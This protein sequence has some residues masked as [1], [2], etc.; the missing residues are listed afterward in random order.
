MRLLLTLCA[1]I[2]LSFLYAQDYSRCKIY[3]GN[4][5]LQALAALGIAVDHGSGK[6]N[7]FFISDF[8]AA[9]IQAIA[10]HG[11]TYEVLIPDVKAHYRDQNRSAGSGNPK[12]ASCAQNNTDIPLPVTPN[13]FHLGTMGGYYTYEEFLAELDAMATAYPQLITLKAPIST[14]ESHEGRPLYWVRISDNPNADEAEPEVLYSSIHHAREPASLSQLIYYMWYLLENY[15]DNGEIAFLLNNTELYFVPM[16]NPDGY[17]YNQVNDPD[18]GGMWRKNRRDNGNG[19]YGVD[20][21]RNYSYQWGTT[22][23]SMDPAT[24]TYPGT[25]AFSEPETQAMKWF[26]ENRDFQLAL[27]AHTY[28]DKLLHPIGTTVE[29]FAEDHAFFEAITGH[30]VKYNGYVHQKSSALYPA[31]GDSDDYMYKVDLTEK[32]EILAMTP[33]IGSDDDGFWPA[34]ADI[35][36][37]CQEMLFTNLTLAHLTHRYNIV[38]DT[39]P[40]RISAATGNFNH[41]AYRLGL[42]DGTISVSITP[43]AGIQSVG[44]PV[45]HSLASMETANG[46]IAYV[47]NADIDYDDEIKYVLNT[48]YPG[49]TKHDTI[50]K[51]FGLMTL[52]FVDVADN[53]ANWT[54]NWATTTSTYYSAT[55]SFTDSPGSNYANMT[56]RTY[57]LNDT[58]DLTNA[59]AAGVSFYA[60]WDIES[61]Y[62]YARMEVSTDNGATWIGQC[63]NYTVAGTSG[64]GSVQPE[65]QPVYEG[66]QPQWVNEEINLDDYLGE[67]IR[68]RFILRSDGG[69]TADGFYFDD[70]KISYNQN[71]PN[72][73]GMQELDLQIH[74]V[75][76]PANEQVYVSFGNPVR[77]GNLSWFDQNGKCVGTVGISE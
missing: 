21:N 13:H 2:A 62:D 69:Q 31:S 51:K 14:F 11:F 56:T 54:G 72:T 12:N 19:L 6:E 17:V 46:A 24:D 15:A 63:G 47:L 75:P 50:V 8:S 70:F 43:L 55:R 36:G 25:G 18:G 58:I 22:G 34:S 38:Q 32:P 74:T 5:G 35:L 27:N 64:S 30:M 71:P 77:G 67:H 42:E 52:Q 45:S 10:A 41:S 20:L 65:G 9:E 39:D 4:D 23:V 16:V 3:T 66:T 1:S 49:W 28:S 57:V 33:E 29:E 48:V 59:S 26:C 60:K 37:I 68:I 73:S 7:T 53:N 76:N 61:N 44:N 40:N